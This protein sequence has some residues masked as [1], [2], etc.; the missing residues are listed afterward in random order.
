MKSLLKNNFIDNLIFWGI[1]LLVICFLPFL[2]NTSNVFSYI[3]LLI[4]LYL[5]DSGHVY[6]TFIRV[7]KEFKYAKIFFVIVPL[8][9]FVFLY[10]IAKY[11]YDLFF[12]VIGYLTIF[13]FIR[14]IYG[15]NRWYIKI[16]NEELTQLRDNIIY[17]VTLIPI[18]IFFFRPAIN[19]VDYGYQ[20]FFLNT[21]CNKCIIKGLNVV[22][23]IAVFSFLVQELLFYKKTKFINLNRILYVLGTGSI[24]WWIGNYATTPLDVILPLVMT[25]GLTYYAVTIKFEKDFYN[26]SFIKALLITI[27]VGTVFGILINYF[28]NQD[29][30]YENAILLA[31]LFTPLIT[32]Y[33][34][35]M[36]IWLHSYLSKIK[37]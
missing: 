9:V 11:D 13:H 4:F 23:F 8:T 10:Y 16:N 31:L 35:D 37:K 14:Q 28:Y 5:F 17:I 6:L 22:F 12:Y 1:P 29:Y 30:M 18:I 33:I 25:H 26:F 32:H 2:K 19:T 3:F 34:I 15:I 36:R 24:F 7:F 27:T 20:F 21:M